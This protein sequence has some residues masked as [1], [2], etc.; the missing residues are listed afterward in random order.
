[1]EEL[2]FKPLSE[3]LGFY[4]KKPN[5][6]SASSAPKEE[7]T[8]LFSPVLPDNLFSAELD[9]ENS[10]DYEQ[11][12]FQLEKPWLGKEVKEEKKNNRK[13]SSVCPTSPP[14]SP[15]VDSSVVKKEPVVDKVDKNVAVSLARKEKTSSVLFEKTFCFSL[16]SYIVDFFVAGFLFFPSLYLFIFLTQIEPVAV[17]W[18]LWPK[19]LVGFLLFAQIYCFLCRLFCFETCGEA[20]A[21]IRLYTL[22]SKKEVHPLMLFWRFL[23]SCSTGII[24]LPLIS[25]IFR[26]DYL[27]RLTGL[28]FQKT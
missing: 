24:L 6:N 8:S 9:L 14:I 28:Y 16:K 17:L 13:V 20:L 3:G 23:V 19:I 11:L 4:E 26:K 18:S 22:R 21:K 2:S 10:Q 15:S 7:S 1:M 5:F 25:L 12:L 27:A